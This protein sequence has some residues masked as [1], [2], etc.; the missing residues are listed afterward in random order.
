MKV[1]GDMEDGGGRRLFG[2]GS[3]GNV[4]KEVGDKEQKLVGC[5]ER[6]REKG[7]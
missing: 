4:G 6:G 1:I 7:Q 2:V 3:R 5:S